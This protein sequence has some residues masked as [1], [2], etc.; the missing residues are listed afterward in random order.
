MPTL[1]AVAFPKQVVFAGAVTGLTYG[2]MAV[3]LILVFRSARVINFAIGDMGAFSAALLYRLVIDWNVPFWIA[4]LAGIAVGACIGA[5]IELVV[6]RRLFSAP[7]V[8]LLVALIGVA[9]LLQF[10]QLILP[11]ITKIRPYPTAF[12]SSWTVGGVI[13]RGEEL[14]ALLVIPAL[15]IVLT[16]FMKKTRYGLA[17]RASAANADAARLSAMSIKKMS[18]LVWIICGVLA[19]TSA[20]LFAPLSPGGAAALAQGGGALDTGPSI[21]LRVLAAA[22]IAGMS[23]MPLALVGGV[24]IGVVEN[25]LV[26]NYNAQRGLVEVVLFVL[27]LVLLLVGGR[28]R[29]LA[30]ADSGRWSFAPRVKPIPAVLQNTWWVRSLPA[31]GVGIVT[32]VAL[33]PLLLLHL[34]SQRVSWSEVL[35]YGLVAL[36]L[37]VLTGWAGQ[38]SLGQFAFVGLGGMT[39]AVLVRNGVGFIPAVLLAGVLTALVA[40]LVG[41]PALRRPGLYL[42]VT[43]FAFA[44]MTSTWLLSQH[45]FTRG[46]ESV[47][48]PR[49]V[50]PLPS[51]LFE[52]GWELQA[53]GSYYGL[54]LV[55][56]TLVVIGCGLLQRSRLGRSFIAVRDNERAAA[57]LGISP[58]KVKIT[59]FAISGWIAGVAGALFVGLL[60]TTSAGDYPASESLRVISIVVIGG[61]S[62]I[63]GAL[64]GAFWVIGLPK[65]FDNTVEIALLTSG[66]GL[67]VLLLYFPGGLVQVFY[68]ARD[69]AFAAIARRRPEP[70]PEPKAERE[71]IPVH[72]QLRRA[73]VAQVYDVIRVEQLQVSCGP[74]LVV[75]G[76]DLRVHS[77]EI[78][79]LIGANGAGK[80]TLM[81]A[82]G[83]FLRS[84]GHVEILGRDVGRLSAARRARLGLG[85]S[86]QGAELFQD[87]TVRETVGL[88][89]PGVKPW[90]RIARTEADEVIAFLGLGSFVDRFINELS[91]G[92][93]RIVELACLVAS[94]STVLCL[95]EPTAGI[96]QRETEAF[97]PLIVRIRDE[98]QASLLIIE[99]DMPVIM[100]ISDR[101]Y[102]MEAGRMICDGAPEQVRRDPLVIAS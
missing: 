63:A 46:L 75:D 76:V 54:C 61:L 102:C 13:V 14:T 72:P 92:T 53:Q 26:F 5:A 57:A 37:T 34:P 42:A 40:M 62:S 11:K 32:L 95:D 100:G 43:T 31:L 74:R 27:I 2:V 49:Q 78:V 89:V 73:A 87:L 81:N 93:R 1:L 82:V 8:I 69:A 97:G 50:I 9:Q 16:I 79:G 29:G 24:A 47:E 41:A 101:V 52:H 64:L 22:L 18:T 71:A 60:T 83:G 55:V 77:G 28:R 23:S 91:T 70:R 36:S 30:E 15:V 25:V 90:Q 7:R 66:A 65:L 58:V 56:L 33:A 39:A 51:G 6:V 68:S 44:V 98:L 88:A 67:L 86:F 84:R 17:I 4:L 19:S 59:A 85:R 20:M 12:S 48:L 38:L 96:A 99:H 3:G 21:L 94:E 80:S 35:L 45:L 10:A